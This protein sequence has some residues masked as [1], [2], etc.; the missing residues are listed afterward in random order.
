MSRSPERRACPSPALL[1]QHAYGEL[2]ADVALLASEHLDSC[3]ECRAYVDGVGR[4]R[5]AY[6]SL[7]APASRGS[8]L[9]AISGS[10]RGSPDLAPPA[11]APGVRARGGGWMAAAAVA[12]VAFAAG[13]LTTRGGVV[14][15]GSTPEPRVFPAGP[16]SYAAG[17]S[18]ITRLGVVSAAAEHGADDPAL[19]ELLIRVLETDPSPNVRLAAVDALA[20]RSPERAEWARLATALQREP[21][22][23]IRLALIDLVAAGPG[24][25]AAILRKLAS[26]DADESVRRWAAQA[27]E[28]SL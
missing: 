23:A 27:L 16:V 5:A 6:E 22:P 9:D 19:T 13:V 24:G 17:S 25:G 4:V 18:A 26:E 14:D 1:L 7:P 11:S 10:G 28:E 12:A 20:E 21:S 8:T 2:D 15:R 3:A